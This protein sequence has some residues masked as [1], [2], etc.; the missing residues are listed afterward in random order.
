MRDTTTPAIC[1]FNVPLIVKRM[2]KSRGEES[3]VALP[4]IKVETEDIRARSSKK[5]ISLGIV[6]NGLSHKLEGRSRVG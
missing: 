4:N 3:L 5:T 2:T 6:L 1:L